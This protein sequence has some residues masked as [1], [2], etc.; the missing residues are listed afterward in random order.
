MK[1]KIL[2][3]FVLS[4][5]FII[6]E[7]VS[8]NILMEIISVNNITEIMSI[9][10]ITEIRSIK[11]IYYNGDCFSQQYY[12]ENVKLKILRRF[13]LSNVFIITEIV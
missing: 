6:T 4:N 8:V 2:R 10:N 1:F 13:V 9:Q 5:L 3:R 12:G 7:I 11:L